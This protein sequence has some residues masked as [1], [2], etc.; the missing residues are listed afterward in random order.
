MR[1]HLFTELRQ[2]AQAGIPILNGLFM[3]ALS[4]A[5]RGENAASPR[6]GLFALGL[7]LVLIGEA[8]LLPQH[9]TRVVGLM[10][11]AAYLSTFI[12]CL[13][14]VLLWFGIHL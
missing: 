4:F 7:A 14:V 3:V 10:R 13:L 6:I 5:F 2:R 11:S 9:S 12:G 1:K 8:E